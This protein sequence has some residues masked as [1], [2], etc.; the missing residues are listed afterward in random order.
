[1]IS[2]RNFSWNERH[3]QDADHISQRLSIDRVQ[4]NINSSGH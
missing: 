3:D 2:P 4:I 1:M